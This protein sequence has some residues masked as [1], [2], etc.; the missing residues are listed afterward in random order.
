[1][2]SPGIGLLL[3]N[4][5]EK[6]KN[7]KI[8]IVDD[9]P[10]IRELGKSILEKAGFTNAWEAEDGVSASSLLR[11]QHFDVV[12]CD[13]EM[14][15]MDGLQLLKEVRKDG[16]MRGTAFLMAT[17]IADV[18]NVKKAIQEGVT[19]YITKPLEPDTFCKKVLTTYARSHSRKAS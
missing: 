5:P 7:I 4:I 3:M 16:R 17:V 18:E 10:T 1:M 11:G 14:P 12:V 15:N 8:L 9:D 13:W 6:V 19:D 2:N